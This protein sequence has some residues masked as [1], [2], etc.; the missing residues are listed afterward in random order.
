MIA[1]DFDHHPVAVDQHREL[2]GGRETGDGS[3]VFRMLRVDHP[4]FER[5]R[6]FVEGDQH[7]P[8]EGCE[9]VAID[10]Q[11]RATPALVSTRALSPSYNRRQTGSA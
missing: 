10:L 9:R 3:P 2:A 5:N 1:A 7:L 4:E 8:V 11:H 6:P